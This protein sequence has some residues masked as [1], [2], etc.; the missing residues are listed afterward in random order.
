MIPQYPSDSF[1]FLFQSL[2]SLLLF[3]LFLLFFL[4][5]VILFLLHLFSH[6]QTPLLS[7]FSSSLGP[8]SF[9]L[10]TSLP[11]PFISMLTPQTIRK[12]IA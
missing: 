4:C 12:V 1:L 8:H 7:V 5:V 10:P 6:N 2:S 3:T 9:P 11:S